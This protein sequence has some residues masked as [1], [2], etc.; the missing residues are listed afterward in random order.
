M[1]FREKLAAFLYGRYG[2]DELYRLLFVVFVICFGINIFIGSLILGIAAWMIYAYAVF[3]VFS[4]NIAARRKEN[5]AYLLIRNKIKG[6][7]SLQA[8]KW[9]E[10]KTHVFKKCPHCKA[11]VRLPRVEGKHGVNCPKCRKHFEVNI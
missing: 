5:Y 6:F 10:R 8:R 1:R 11:T 9:R 2:A 3:R 4:R 7:F